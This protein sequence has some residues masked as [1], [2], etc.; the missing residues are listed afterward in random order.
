M[1]KTIKRLAAVFLTAVFFLGTLSAAADT[2]TLPN[3]TDDMTEASYWAGRQQTPK[4]VM[5]KLDEIEELNAAFL[6]K[7]DCFM[8]DLLKDYPTYDETSLQRQYLKHAMRT[9]AEYMGDGYYREDGEQV[10]LDDVLGILENIDDARTLP[11]Q[12]VRY[13]ICVS[14]GNVRTVPSDLLVT[15]ELG[16]NDFD[17]LQNSYVR[18]NEPVVIQT[19]TAD[20]KW[21]Y[22]DTICVDGWIPAENIAICKDREEWLSAFQIPNEELVVVTQG[23]LYLDEA[24]V[25]G[26]S[27]ERMLTMGTTLRKVSEEDFDSLLTNRA[28]YHN[29]AVWLPVRDEEG[30]YSTTIG[31]LPQHSEVSMGYLPL[32]TENILNV[33]FSMLG[34]AYGWG[35][36]LSVPD[37][38]LYIRN[39]YKCFGLELPRNTTWQA[40]MP[41]RSVELAGMD[42][43]EKAKA[44]SMLP[45]GAILFFRGHEMMYLGSVKGKHYVISCVGTIMEPGGDSVMRVRSVV[46]NTLEDTIRGNGNSWLDDLYRAVIPYLPVEV[47]PE[48]TEEETEE[49]TETA[50]EIAETTA[51][52]AGAAVEEAE[53]SAEDTAGEE[54]PAAEAESAPENTESVSVEEAVAGDETSAEEGKAG[55]EISSPEEGKA[56]EEISSAEEELTA[57]AEEE[58]GEEDTEK[59]TNISSEEA[60][61]EEA[62]ETLSEETENMT[63]DEPETQAPGQPEESVSETTDQAA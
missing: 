28:L 12:E 58:I 60:V 5:A 39:I 38:S 13:G 2:A 48:E 26:A 37:C 32:T 41:A 62:E 20:G 47:I 27:S 63:P 7:E 56:G 16:D 18:V 22:C 45:A 33:A 1:R 35:G 57:E 52:E 36:M 19:Q 31:L 53:T 17:D 3:V 11:E 4:R 21:Y 46:I 23:K 43:E 8:F 9:L 49:V 50:A 44:I 42:T 34:D 55:E 54:E 29:T 40:A 6:A 24:N 30:R 14:L 25:N 61:S 15:D 59:E 51:E 10:R